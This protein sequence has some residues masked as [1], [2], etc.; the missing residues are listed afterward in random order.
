MGAIW[1][2]W[3]VVKQWGG[4]TYL[5]IAKQ[6]LLHRRK[7]DRAKEVLGGPS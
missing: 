1:G 2:I 4:K 6:V 5:N 7:S 3:G